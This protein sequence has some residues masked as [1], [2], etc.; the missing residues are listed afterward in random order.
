MNKNKKK[1]LNTITDSISSWQMKDDWTPEKIKQLRAE[2]HKTQAQL[3]EF[4][5]V[6]Q[7]H[8]GHLEMGFRSAGPQT[9]RLL[10]VLWR[11]VNA[12]A[13]AGVRS[14]SR[15]RGTQCKKPR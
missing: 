12:D 10:E 5:G 7:A 13:G 9:A 15:K 8:V 3:A 1:T 4:L 11:S 6:T 14:S 2:G